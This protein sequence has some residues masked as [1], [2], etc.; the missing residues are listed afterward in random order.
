M[1]KCSGV[2]VRNRAAYWLANALFA[3]VAVSAARAAVGEEGIV[4]HST[5]SASARPTQVEMSA[6]L[7]ADAELAADAAVKFRDAKKRALAALAALK[8]SDLSVTPG[9]V[10]VATSLDSNAQQMMMMRGISVGSTNQKVRI[11]ETNRIVLSQADK[12][13]PEELLASLLKILDVAKDAGFQFA[14]PPTNDYYEMQARAQEGQVVFLFKLPDSAVLRKKAYKA[15]IDDAKAR[16]QELADLSA[17]KLGRILS[18][19]EGPGSNMQ[20][21][22]YYSPAMNRGSGEDNAL[23]GVTSGEVTMRVNLTVQFEIAK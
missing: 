3:F 16:A 4:V 8:N 5:G 1:S 11:T 14:L 18:V 2:L 21:V 7:S 20:G 10:S 23:T 12:L 9:G 22:V 6:K 13:E 15:A 17:I 19:Q